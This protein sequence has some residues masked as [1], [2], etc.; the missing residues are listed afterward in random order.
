M[1][2]MNLRLPDNIYA[3]VKALAEAE[4]RSIHAELLWLIDKALE[5]RS[6][7]RDSSPA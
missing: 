7:R 2:Q 6:R 1:K 4:R 3:Q 5:A